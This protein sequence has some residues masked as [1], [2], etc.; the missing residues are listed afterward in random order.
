MFTRCHKWLPTALLSVANVSNASTP[1]W[2]YPARRPAETA[3]RGRVG[4][5]GHVFLFVLCARAQGAYAE[6]RVNVSN[7][8]ISCLFNK[9][10]SM[11]ESD[12]V[13]RMET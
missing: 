3:I 11:T 5:V 2:T 8:S 10:V 1:Q 4:H 7:V 9:E 13:L 12:Y 6:K